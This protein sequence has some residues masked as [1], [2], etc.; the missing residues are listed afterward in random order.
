VHRT[1]E[2]I[3]TRGLEALREQLGRAGMIRFLQQFDSG[4][5][6]YTV[7]RRAWVGTTTLDD[8]KQQA[9]RRPRRSG[10]KPG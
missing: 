5:G 9:G 7:E 2:D 8:L 3:R 4:S 10:K 1:L 6:D